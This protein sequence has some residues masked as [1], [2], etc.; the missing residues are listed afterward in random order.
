VHIPWSSCVID[1]PIGAPSLDLRS[2]SFILS[3][4]L[5]TKQSFLFILHIHHG[6][7]K[8]RIG[9]SKSILLFSKLFCS[10]NILHGSV[11]SVSPI[12]ELIP[13]FPYFTCSDFS[14][15]SGLMASFSV[16]KRFFFAGV[17]L[18]NIPTCPDLRLVYQQTPNSTLCAHHS[19]RRR[20]S[21]IHKHDD[22]KP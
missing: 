16:S 8:K 19:Q 2:K 6:E 1:H 4:T 18:S 5:K 21:P 20:L 13:F 14:Q 7:D 9:L 17:I 22:I 3:F 10:A 15:C 12:S 11:V